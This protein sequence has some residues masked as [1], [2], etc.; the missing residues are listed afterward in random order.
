MRP[1]RNQLSTKL[2]VEAL[3]REA[4]NLKKANGMQHA[5]ALDTVAKSYGFDKW[6]AL[7]AAQNE[8][9]RGDQRRAQEPYQPRH[10]EPHFSLEEQPPEGA[11]ASPFDNPAYV[12]QIFRA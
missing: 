5:K 9:E 11:H 1:S 3:R 8:L 10:R 12:R 6:T 2:D 4:H 7:V